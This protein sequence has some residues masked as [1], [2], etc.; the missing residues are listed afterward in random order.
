MRRSKA[1]GDGDKGKQ[2]S[3]KGSASRIHS[4]NTLSNLV[5]SDPNLSPVQDNMSQFHSNCSSRRIGERTQ[6]LEK[7]SHSMG[8]RNCL[9]K[10]YGRRDS[11][12][13]HVEDPFD[14]CTTEYYS[15]G[16]KETHSR[17]LA[18]EFSHEIDHVA[19]DDDVHVHSSVESDTD[20]D[21]G[22]SDEP[23]MKAYADIHHAG[24]KVKLSTALK[25]QPVAQLGEVLLRSARED[26]CDYDDH[27]DT[28]IPAERDSH[29][30]ADSCGGMD[31]FSLISVASDDHSNDAKDKM[32]E[33]SS[34][35]IENGAC[36]HDVMGDETGCCSQ[37]SLAE[38]ENNWEAGAFALASSSARGHRR[39]FPLPL[40]SLAMQ[41]YCDKRG[42][43]PGAWGTCHCLRSLRRDGRFLLQE[44][45][46]P[47]H[48]YFTVSRKDGRL[49][50]ELINPVNDSSLEED[51]AND[52]DVYA[53]LSG[54]NH[55][56]VNVGLDRMPAN[57]QGTG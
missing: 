56:A 36:A 55:V 46:A 39:S 25:V 57:I 30:N 13:N 52:S 19:D 15:C 40:N 53:G 41:S 34:I 44:V 48:R 29:G 47:T 45:K 22:V 7:R 35:F 49:K 1:S 6:S 32:V 37:Q 33:F 9:A 2:L 3:R 14:K 26:G 28:F 20:C 31:E 27:D 54:S 12:R 42:Q 43:S 51:E 16:K 50:L 10:L 38:E 11:V 18:S 24:H 5:D 21:T 23:C 8:F 4:I 17:R